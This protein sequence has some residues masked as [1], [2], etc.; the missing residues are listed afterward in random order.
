M[1]R[2]SRLNR[3]SPSQENCWP[4]IDP[5]LLSPEPSLRLPP[6]TRSILHRRFAR[7]RQEC[8]TGVDADPGSVNGGSLDRTG[9]LVGTRFDPLLGT[10]IAPDVLL[11]P[12]HRGAREQAGICGVVIADRPL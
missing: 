1:K 3:S 5:P 2:P 4:A 6:R 12:R 8:C 7:S 9:G 11:L 10:C